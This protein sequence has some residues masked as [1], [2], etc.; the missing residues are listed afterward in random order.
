MIY[1]NM[2]KDYRYKKELN[3]AELMMFGCILEDTHTYHNAVMFCN[4]IFGL[5]NEVAEESRVQLYEYIEENFTMISGSKEYKWTD[6]ND[7]LNQ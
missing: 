2:I 5:F 6:K 3:S 4:D 7:M 1:T